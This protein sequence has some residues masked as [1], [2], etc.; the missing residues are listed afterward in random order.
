MWTIPEIPERDTFRCAECDAVIAASEHDDQPIES[1][2][3]ESGRPVHRV[4]TAGGVEVH[5]C[6]S[7]FLML[8]GYVADAGDAGSVWEGIATARA[9]VAE[10][11][12]CSPDDA[13]RAMKA[14]AD[15][16]GHPIGMFAAGVVD[17]R[18]LMDG[19]SHMA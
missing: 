8:S 2:V 14:R 6:L 19:E 1:F 5:R 3:G 7:P 12:G 17:G 15:D 18:Q 9:I 10:Q 16:L 13:L 11:R 4:V